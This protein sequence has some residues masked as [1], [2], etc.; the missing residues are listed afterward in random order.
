MTP[1]EFIQTLSPNLYFVKRF[2]AL[3][4][5]DR[6]FVMSK[7]KL[8]NPQY[9]YGV[10]AVC[11]KRDTEE[12]NFDA[13]HVFTAFHRAGLTSTLEVYEGCVK[14]YYVYPHLP[15]I[16]DKEQITYEGTEEDR[17]CL[18]KYFEN[19]H[20]ALGERMEEDRWRWRT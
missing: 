1:T 17:A 13:K 2:D 14:P 16:F 10:V 12:G 9:N 15:E 8:G 19:L 20:I 3:I 7:G 5:E 6:L 4:C 18:D 11:D